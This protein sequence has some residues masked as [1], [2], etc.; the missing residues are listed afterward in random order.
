MYYVY[1]KNVFVYKE[2]IYI[3]GQV[4]ISISIVT[5][6]SR[7]WLN[8]QLTISVWD[9]CVKNINSF[10]VFKRQLLEP[11]LKIDGWKDEMDVSKNSVFLSPKM[12]GLFH[13]K[14]YSLM[15]DLGVFPLFL[16]TPKCPF[17]G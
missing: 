15:D 6:S 9:L 8:T 4:N 17:G 5:Y 11:V 14:H 12:D 7:F 3:Y 1:I 16:E 2:H 13:G 10:G